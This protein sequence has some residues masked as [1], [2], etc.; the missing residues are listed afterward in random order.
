MNDLLKKLQNKNITINVIDNQLDIKAPKGACMRF[1][2][3]QPNT[4]CLTLA[5]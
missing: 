4:F 5:S 3:K 1:G 2:L